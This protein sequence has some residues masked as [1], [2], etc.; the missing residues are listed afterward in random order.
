MNRV[1]SI[2]RMHLRDKF[3]W[4]FVPLLVVGSSFLVNY[5]LS[6]FM[7]EPL[8]TGGSA[9][10]YVYMFITGILSLAQTF[11]FAIGLS[12]RRT[13]FFLGTLYMAAVMSA[14]IA[15]FHLLLS[16]IEVSSGGWGTDLHFFDLPYLNEGM[17]IEQFWTYFIISLTMYFGGFII[18]SVYRRFGMVGMITFSLVSLV[19]ITIVVFLLSYYGWWGDM[20]SVIFSQ[21]ASQ[22]ANWLVILLAINIGVSYVFIR[23]ATV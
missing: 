3:T 21:S 20:F 2:L 1:S 7:E 6:F 9:S 22:L 23:K 5:V 12:V 11:P 15:I 14:I 18:S 13:D 16:W 10:L 4:F 8:Y 17:V 19:L